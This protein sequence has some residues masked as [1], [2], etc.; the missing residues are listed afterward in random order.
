VRILP[1]ALAAVSLASLSLLAT[2]ARAQ[3][4]RPA[5]DDFY[6][7][8]R[9]RAA[10]MERGIGGQEGACDPGR[11]VA[12]LVGAEVADP[13]VAGRRVV[14]AGAHVGV[15]AGLAWGRYDLIRSRAWLGLLRASDGGNGNKVLADATLD[16]ALFQT[17][18]PELHD[19]FGLHLALSPRLVQRAELEPKDLAELR[20]A[21][22]RMWD[23]EAEVAPIGPQ[24]DKDGRLAIPLGADYRAQWDQDGAL[25]ERR[26]TL[27]GAVSLRG[28]PRGVRHHLQFDFARL[29]RVDWSTAAGHAHGWSTSL[30]WQRL[31]PDLKGIDLWILGG[32]G[33]YAGAN[34][35]HGP[36]AQIG[37]EATDDARWLFGASYDARFALD[38]RTNRF[39]RVHDAKAYGRV[40]S[41]ARLQAGA[42][43]ELVGVAGEVVVAVTPELLARVG[44]LALAA[45]YRVVMAHAVPLLEAP[46]DDRL[47]V[48]VD[49]V[50]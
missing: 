6:E 17:I 20:L 7:R 47:S 5:L 3:L 35:K 36:L 40:L 4:S 1:R 19:D 38:Y 13:I 26:T 16:T 24:I 37:V 28:F 15:D 49:L 12:F 42:S 31:S 32:W 14:A 2:S 44:M 48:G 11:T 29:T 10:C 8:G 25:L 33:W 9:T 21:P 23:L 18:N 34:D 22:Y 27:S 45:R 39:Y 50:F 46:L 41:S 30:G 43:V